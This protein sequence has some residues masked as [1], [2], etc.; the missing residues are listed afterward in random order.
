MLSLSVPGKVK[1]QFSRF[2]Y[3]HKR[4]TSITRKPQVQS[5][6]TWVSIESLSN[7]LKKRE[8]NVLW[9]QCFLLLLLLMLTC[10][11][12]MMSEVSSVLALTKRGLGSERVTF[13]VKNQKKFGFCWN[14]LKNNWPTTWGGFGWFL[15]FFNYFV[16]NIFSCIEH[17][18]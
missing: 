2:Q 13:S 17:I 12:I 4:F 9:K 11:Q 7:T 8:N 5:L 1:T 6:S 14:C 15:I 16:Q 18:F 3:F 10:F